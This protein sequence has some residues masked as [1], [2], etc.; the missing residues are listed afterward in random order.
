MFFYIALKHSTY[1][2]E[3]YSKYML[4]INCEK[5]KK[6]MIEKKIGEVFGEHSINID[7]K[8]SDKSSNNFSKIHKEGKKEYCR[9]LI[10]LLTCWRLRSTL[11]LQSTQNLP[12]LLRR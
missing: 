7:L 2:N 11:S 12:T 4:I 3:H 1:Y 5:T 10:Y 8:M 9:S 6:K